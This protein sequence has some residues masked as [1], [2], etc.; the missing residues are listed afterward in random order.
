MQKKIERKS[1]ILYGYIYMKLPEM[2]KLEREKMYQWLLGC[3]W[4]LTENKRKGNLWGGGHVLRLDFGESC[5]TVQIY[6]SLSS[7]ILKFSYVWGGCL[8]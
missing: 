2:E 7:Y 6:E 5:T 8:V 3:E 1:H 4:E